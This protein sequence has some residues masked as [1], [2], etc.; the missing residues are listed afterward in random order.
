M[1]VEVSKAESSNTES[2]DEDEIT[3][4]ETNAP[5]NNE[6]IDY[7]IIVQNLLKENS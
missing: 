7:E 2:S 5:V 3:R 6:E 1:E 4:L